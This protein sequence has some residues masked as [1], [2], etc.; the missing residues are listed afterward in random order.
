MIIDMRNSPASKELF[1]LH[2]LDQQGEKQGGWQLL[3]CGK[4]KNGGV[5]E[6]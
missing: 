1:C 6:A 4:G 3:L 2:H 5:V